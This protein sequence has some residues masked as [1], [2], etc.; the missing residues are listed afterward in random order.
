MISLGLVD[1]ITSTGDFAITSISENYSLFEIGGELDGLLD[2]ATLS[3]IEC[4]I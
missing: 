2:V 3:H 1:S 4:T